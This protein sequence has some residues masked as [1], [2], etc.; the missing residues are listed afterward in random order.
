MLCLFEDQQ[1]TQFYPLSDTR[2]LADLLVGTFTQRERATAVTGDDRIVLHGRSAILRHCAAGGVDVSQPSDDTLFI[3]ARLPLSRSRFDSFPTGRQWVL[4]HGAEVVAARLHAAN[5]SR[6]DWAAD[7]LDFTS[8]PDVARVD[9]D[10]DVMYRHVWDLIGDNAERIEH[11]VADGLRPMELRGVVS[12]GAHL[13]SRGSIGVG[14]GSTVSPG[15]VI[16]ASHGPVVIGSGVE[17]M[18]GAVLQGPLFVGDDSRV[19]IGAKIYG[20][21]SIGPWCKIGGEVECS[22]VLGYSNKQHDGFLGHSYL[23]RWVN[24]GADTNTSDLKN[25]Y[26]MIRVTLRGATVETNRMFLGSVIGDHVKTSINTMLNTG[27]VIGVGAN[28]FGAGFPPKEIPAFAW[29]ADGS[30]RFQ[31]ARALELAERVMARRKVPFTD[32]DR[33]L[34]SHLYDAAG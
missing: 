7:Q 10:E 25:N 31:L 15:A 3:N 12:S 5:V 22:I 21:T 6:L 29:G 2:H 19:K 18:P 9:T 20:E 16:D 26:G 1:V 14:V 32:A 17:V 11:D 27:T 24:L 4:R 34:L 13:I 30:S 28:V 33:V 23:G 8:L